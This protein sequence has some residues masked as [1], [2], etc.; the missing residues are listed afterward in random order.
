MG[1]TA[2]AR[3]W[4]P[5][6]AGTHCPLAAPSRG[7]RAL[8]LSL[9]RA[10][11]GDMRS[12]SLISRQQQ[13]PPGCQGRLPALVG[14]QIAQIRSRDAGGSPTAAGAPCCAAAALQA[15]TSPCWTSGP[16][17]SP[18]EVRPSLQPCDLLSWPGAQAPGGRL[19]LRLQGASHLAPPPPPP[20]RRWHP[21]LLAHG[22]P[23]PGPDARDD[24]REG[25]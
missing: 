15:C 20:P 18:K 7:R 25:H 24:E 22:A 21:R 14:G 23:A 16:T 12:D 1:H 4:H 6:P 2:H 8:P 17:S 9:Q 13:Q 10:P 19:R 3:C 11:G 5:L